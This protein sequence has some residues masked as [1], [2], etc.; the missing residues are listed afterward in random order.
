M[1]NKWKDAFEA[2]VFTEF[3]EQRAPGHTVLGDKI[4]RKGFFDFKKEIKR[5]FAHLF[6]PPE[7]QQKMDNPSEGHDIARLW[8]TVS[9]FFKK[10]TDPLFSYV[11]DLI[12]RT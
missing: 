7:M 4:Y 1:T 8:E 11:S 2:G 9:I 10:K 5:S 3:M 12:Y 6:E